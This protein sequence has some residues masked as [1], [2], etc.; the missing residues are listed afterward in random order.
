MDDDVS[1]SAP[2]GAGRQVKVSVVPVHGAVVDGSGWQ[3]VHAILAARGVDASHAVMLAQPGEVAGCIEA[4][5]WQ[6]A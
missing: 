6:A 2:D 1:H 3:P 5:A 4:A